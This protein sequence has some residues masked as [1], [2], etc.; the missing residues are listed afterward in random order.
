MYL[1]P[2]HLDLGLEIHKEV[3]KHIYHW[4]VPNLAN[5]LKNL[6]MKRPFCLNNLVP[7]RQ[8]VC[9]LIQTALDVPSP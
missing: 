6:G 4:H 2:L 5:P 3:V 9:Y 8:A 7:V 1:L